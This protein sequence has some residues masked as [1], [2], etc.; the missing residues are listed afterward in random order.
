MT[1]GDQDIKNKYA[2]DP[3]GNI[4]AQ[5]EASGLS[6]PF[7]YVGQFGVMT[8]PNGLYYMRARYYDPQVGRFISEDPIGFGGGDVNLYAYVGGNPIM[9][10]DPLGLCGKNTSGNWIGTGIGENSAEWYA[11]KYN[12]TGNIAYAVGG[13]LASLWTPETYVKTAA[14][15]AGGYLVGSALSPAASVAPKFTNFAEGE[16]SRG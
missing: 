7:K 5:Q 6:Q 3:F 11:N 15:L 14:T 10:I 2:Y 16:R 8:E 4:A 1:D 12:E 9:G 13:S